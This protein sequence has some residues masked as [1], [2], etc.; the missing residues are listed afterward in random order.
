MPKVYI[1]ESCIPANTVFKKNTQI[2]QTEKLFF[3]NV[4]DTIFKDFNNNCW[5]YI[6]EY[7]NYKSPNNVF[8]FSY[9]GNYFTKS[10]ELSPILFESCTTCLQTSTS[11]CTKVFYDAIKCDNTATTVTI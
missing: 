11:A 4:N 3:T 5:R 9:S 10:T 7:D 8:N 1:Y 2:I 6:G